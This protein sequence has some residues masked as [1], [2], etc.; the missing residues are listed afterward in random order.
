MYDPHTDQPDANFE[1]L[2]MKALHGQLT[3]EQELE[4]KALLSASEQ[5]KE[6]YHALLDTHNFLQS[7]SSLHKTFIEPNEVPEPS[8]KTFDNFYQE[9]RSQ[10]KHQSPISGAASKDSSSKHNIFKTRN[11]IMTIAGFGIAAMFVFALIVNTDPQSPQPYSSTGAGNEPDLFTM[12]GGGSDSLP[13]SETAP[14]QAGTPVAFV[15]EPSD[16][17]I[18][19]R[20]SRSTTPKI[21]EALYAGDTLKIPGG[22]KVTVLLTNGQRL[23]EGPLTHAVTEQIAMLT[24]SSPLP[25]SSDTD[26]LEGTR[27][28]GSSADLDSFVFAPAASALATVSMSVNRDTSAIT[29]YAPLRE[30]GLLNPVF[31][32]KAEQGATYSV[33]LYNVIDENES[34]TQSAVTPPLLLKTLTGS[35]SITLKPDSLYAVSISKDGARLSE[36]KFSFMT[37]QDAKTL[38]DDLTPP[39]ALVLM[40]EFAS[41]NR[42]SDV[43][44]LALELPEP[45]RS[46]P[47]AVRL[48]ALAHSKLSHKQ[49]FEALME[50]FR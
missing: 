48:R 23:L 40:Q 16:K 49:A 26:P 38:P 36:S 45:V 13:S 30:T 35:P 17:T 27:G 43:L 6:E 37:S 29:L 34:F 31:D 18:I 10:Q 7:A 33:E 12:R 4:F 24:A 42:W 19:Q 21:G 20:G 3:D 50:E 46:S 25:T 8:Q 28:R 15:L 2:A 1:F 41:K 14:R 11:L 5:K 44:M 47:L 39:E 32:W 9:I 22:Q